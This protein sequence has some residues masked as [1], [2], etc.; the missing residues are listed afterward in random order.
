M[1]KIFGIDLSYHNGTVDF[2]KVKA[3]GVEFVILRCG[4]AS[5]SNRNSYGKD[6]KFE[7][8]YKDAKAAGLAV[9]SYFY[10]RCNNN[11]TAKAE[12]EFILKCIAGKSFEYP[13]WLDVEDQ[14][15]LSSANK[16]TMTTAIETCLDTIKNAGYKVGIYT[17]IYIIRNNLI[18]SRIDKY[19]VWIAQWANSCSYTGNLCMW[20]FGGET[21]KL[22]S[23]KINGVS[24]AACDQNYSAID[25]ANGE[26]S[27]GENN[28]FTG[29]EIT[30]GGTGGNGGNGGGSGGITGP[31]NLYL[32]FNNTTTAQESLPNANVSDNWVDMHRIKGITLHMYP[33]YHNCKADSMATYFKTLG[34]DRNFHYKVDKDTKVDFSKKPVSGSTTGGNKV[35]SSVS[36]FNVT[37]KDPLNTGV[38]ITGDENGVYIDNAGS[39][40]GSSGGGGGGGGDTGTPSAPGT[41]IE[42]SNVA[43]KIYNYCVSQGCSCAAAC[44]IVGNAQRESGFDPTL[45]AYDGSGSIGLFQWLATRRTALEKA[46]KTA[47]V[48]YKDADFQIQ[49]MWSE[50]TSSYYMNQLK[51]KYNMTL[52]DFKA[53]SSP[54][55]AA[56]VFER[57]FEVSAET[58]KLREQYAR[59]WYNKF[60]ASS[61]SAEF[62]EAEILTDEILYHELSETSDEPFGWPVP[63]QQY[64]QSYYGY[65]QDVLGYRYHP[66]IDIVNMAGY[67]AYCY[68]DGRVEKVLTNSVLSGYVRVNHG[69][70]LET[71]YGSLQTIYVQE[72]EKVVGGQC[73]GLTN[74][75]DANSLMHL[76][77]GMKINNQYVDPLYYVQPGGGNK[78]VPD[79]YYGVTASDITDANENITWDNVDKGK[80]CFASAENNT[81]T[82]IDANL[83]NNQH[84]KYTLSIGSFFYDEFDLVEKSKEVDYPATEK[85]LIEQTAKALYDE[86][87]TSKELWREFDLN[88]APSPFLYLDKDKWVAFCTEVDKQVEWLNKKYGIVTATY[89]P[90]EL[91]ENQNKNEFVETAPGGAS[92]NTGGGGGGGDSDG[93]EDTG[94]VTN[95]GSGSLGWPVP[96]ISTI[97]SKFGPRK[98]PTAG[99]STNHKGIDIPGAT[100]TKIVA[101]D[102]GKVVLAKTGYNWGRGTYMVIDHGNGMGTLYQHLSKITAS[103]G[104]SVSKGDKIAEMGNTGIGTGSHLHFEVHTGFSGTKGTPVDPQKYVSAGKS[105]V[106]DFTIMAQVQDGGAGS[107]QIDVSFQQDENSYTGLHLSGLGA[108]SI[109]NGGVMEYSVGKPEDKNAKQPEIKTIITQEEYYAIMEYATSGQIELYANSFEPYDKDLD[110]AKTIG[111]Q[112]D[113]RLGMLTNVLRTMTENIIRYIVVETG[114][115]SIDHCVKPVD[116]LSSLYMISDCMCDPIYP[117][118]IIPPK[119][120][121]SAYDALSKNSIPMR[122]VE[123]ATITL[124]DALDKSYSYDYELLD[125][126][127]KE[128]TGKPINYY[129]PYPY[130]DKITDLENHLPKVLIDEIESRVYSCNHPGCPIAHPMAK[131][132][133]MLN[134]MAINQSKYTEQ[135]L[136]QIE[137]VL[138]TMVRYLGRM[139]SRMNINCVYYG[140]Q[141]VMGKYKCIRCLRDNRIQDG[142]TVTIDQCLSCTRYE[143]IIGQV[144]DILDE[145]G[146]NG[147]AIL[148]DMQMSYMSLDD[149]KNLNLVEKRNTT[150]NYADTNKKEEEI[151]KSL[152]EEWKEKDLAKYKEENKITNDDEISPSKYLFMMDW[153]R[154]AFDLQ[155]P[156]VKDY[157]TEAISAKYYDQAG[158]PGEEVEEKT[159]AEKLAD[160]FTPK[161]VY[162][163]LAEGEWVDTRKE[164]D[165]MEINRY[166]SLDYYF[167][168]FN[169]NRTGYEY[170]NGLVGNVGLETTGG[171]GGSDWGMESVTVSGYNNGGENGSSDEIKDS[172]NGTGSEIRNKI[173]EYAYK[174]VK[175]NKDKEATYCGSHRTVDPNKLVRHGGSRNGCSNPICYDCTGLVSAAYR[176]AGL[177]SFYNK[178]ASGGSLVAEALSNSA[179]IWEG[180]KAGFEKALP[181]DII[182]VAN[183]KISNFNPKNPPSTYHAMIYTGTN[184][185]SHAS[186]NYEPGKAIKTQNVGYNHSHYGGKMFFIR[187]KEL[188]TADAKAEAAATSGSANVVFESGTIDGNKY[189]CKLLNARTT[190][191]GPWDGSGTTVASGKGWSSVVNKSV[192]SHNLPYGTKLY[193]P[194]LKGKVNSTGIFTVEDTGGY[195]FDFDIATSKS[196]GVTGY[197]TAYILSYGSGK[198]SASFTYGR[199]VVDPN[200]TKYV[201]AWKA[202]MAKGGCLIHFSKFNDDDAKASWWK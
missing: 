199:K 154:Q 192:A 20:Q 34:W 133:A 51:K 46:A 168:N 177:S 71:I 195:C 4:Y 73:I 200:G 149:M 118:L 114:P 191:Y 45:A 79:C 35:G 174:V 72:G 28:P 152:I 162:D 93:G 122:T 173:V 75:T 129:D 104:S 50:W 37:P 58:T 42:G 193:I 103:L 25:Y 167:E 180:N 21:N 111:L 92:D 140:G 32:T 87:F 107:P 74:T 161:E 44:G 127:T 56:T 84:A 99:A 144:Y 38:T 9:G 60:S 67:G 134:D 155:R 41:P 98:A 33:P 148:D 63:G 106:G 39:N 198:V 13:I 175:Q 187:C 53:L 70:G 170:D 2:K 182:M 141:T 185:V 109:D 165:N 31:G 86:G 112:N 108:S 135:R 26:E 18:Q 3:E 100:G 22:R 65:R 179:Q 68:A 7:T 123:D 23:V 142:A 90:N 190:E 172:V 14:S 130:D 1:A 24:S 43:T 49:Y 132:F 91:L 97:S 36:D 16:E 178:N 110:I 82:Y 77:F 55:R 102:S 8:Y 101:A 196:Y 125:E 5:T 29:D 116:E 169:Q 94:G 150:Y 124:E 139:S 186:G 163:K 151:P 76:H 188:I 12:A 145:T 19:D 88:R 131:N 202:Y 10:S 189:V 40:G 194:S 80:I 119:Y 64:I 85:I 113:A 115:G 126:V 164:D 160:L 61:S 166:T 156:D 153:N 157:P 117:D 17:G 136:V 59:E 15:T 184:E 105:S 47:G 54:E 62:L 176:Y 57:I 83:F 128:T 30:S 52:A 27:T 96:G 138:A 78:E 159:P 95:P 121:T 183:S 143:P 181:G 89:K 6:T 81:H 171:P 147:S 146:F 48:S 69:N 137:N 158:D 11:A 197:R 201:T 120:V 66:G